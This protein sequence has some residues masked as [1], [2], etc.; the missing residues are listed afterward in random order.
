M[1]SSDGGEEVRV[2]LHGGPS[3]GRLLH[4]VGEKRS[5]ITVNGVGYTLARRLVGD[6]WV[7]S[8]A[9][10]TTADGDTLRGWERLLS[11][12]GIFRGAVRTRQR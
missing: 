10:L 7:F 8:V 4:R 9:P 5:W 2:V 6:I 3:H 11:E 12:P 1:V